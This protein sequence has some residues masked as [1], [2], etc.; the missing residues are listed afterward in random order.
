[1]EVG[2]S[3]CLFEELQQGELVTG[4]FESEEDPG[5][6]QKMSLK[7]FD[8]TNR[9]VFAREDIVGKG[10][11]VF[12][13]SD[14]GKFQFCFDNEHRNGLSSSLCLPLFGPFPPVTR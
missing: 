10:E 6:A 9:K 4:R 1:M 7:V 8:P 12:T 11:V 5:K 3:K 13:A 2:L 14:Q